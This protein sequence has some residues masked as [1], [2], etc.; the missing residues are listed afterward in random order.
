VDPN[1]V[2]AVIAAESAYNPVAVSN[3]GA[4]GLM[5]LIPST[6]RRF[7]VRNIF[8]PD[9]NI[10]GGVKYLRFLLDTFNNDLKLVLAAYNAGENAV[11]RIGGVP[12]YRET[13]GYVNRIVARY[14]QVYRPVQMAALEGNG[15]AGAV[16]AQQ[17]PVVTK[18][19]KIIDPVGNVIYT[20]RPTTD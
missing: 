3:K 7:G 13:V 10:E 8:Y 11:K 6:A 20:N 5:Q 16:A 18:V 4:C 19:Y 1:L 15:P 17:P 14:G 12:N 9:E 2:R